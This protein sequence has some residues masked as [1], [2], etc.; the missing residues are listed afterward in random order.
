MRRI[1]EFIGGLA[2][3]AGLSAAGSAA[4]TALALPVPGPVIG[5]LAYFALLSF[6]IFP[7]SAV[8]ARWLAGLLGALIVPP[9]VGVAAFAPV[10]A[11]GG[12]RLAVA[13]V[14]GCVVTGLVTAATYRA[15]VA[16]QTR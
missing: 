5:L 10:L 15:V 2:L 4:A 8:A 1:A 16:W 14:G 6:G 7:A 3:V 11:A 13:L 9:L 12:W